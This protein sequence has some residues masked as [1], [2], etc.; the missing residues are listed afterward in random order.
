M[1]DKE[2]MAEAAVLYY[3]KGLTQ[4]EIARI[5]YLSRQTVSKL[6]NEAIK[7]NIVEIKIRQPK[8]DC[9]RLEEELQRIFGIKKA[10]VCS[11]ASNNDDI[12]QL[13]TVKAAIEYLVPI[14]EKGEHNIAVSWGRT[15]KLLISQFPS[16][17]T[18]GNRVYPLFG[19][20]DNGE[21]C[22]SSNELARSMA[23]KICADVQ[24]AWFPFLPDGETD[25]ALYKKTSYYQRLCR[26]WEDI[27]IS[28]VGIGNSKIIDFFAD[29][30]GRKENSSQAVGDVA[31]HFFNA[32]G[33]ILPLYQNTLCATTENLKRAKSVIAIAGG[34]DKIQAIQGALR[35]KLI[36]VLVT[37]E[38]TAKSIC[39]APPKKSLF[40]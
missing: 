11:I 36:D 33:E 14:I 1:F 16:L 23:D 26:L 9:A 24:Y 38:Y 12:R 25:R 34:K 22:F 4:Q 19:A 20:T 8:K 29:T 27:D 35:S 2:L 10:V 39:N 17:Q 30:F 13:M 28:L 7:T 37:D 31:T 40:C 18:H 3:E 32:D 21:A 6:L 15:I 5:L